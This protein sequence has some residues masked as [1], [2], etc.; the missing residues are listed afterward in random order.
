[1]LAIAVQ[2]A[3][4]NWLNFFEETHGYPWL[5]K[6][7]EIT[8]LAIFTLNSGPTQLIISKPS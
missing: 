6:S 8:I 4:S 1:M 5:L 3:C 2:M 7:F